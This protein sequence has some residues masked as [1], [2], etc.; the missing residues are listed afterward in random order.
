MQKGCTSGKRGLPC[1]N[2]R[3]PEGPKEA[4]NESLSATY[5]N[6]YPCLGELKLANWLVLHL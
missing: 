6:P 2:V 4:K 1:L 3:T 5:L